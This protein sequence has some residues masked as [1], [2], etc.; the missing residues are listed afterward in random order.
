MKPEN[1]VDTSK[2]NN[3]LEASANI[4]NSYNLALPDNSKIA[5]IS[6]EIINSNYDNT[7]NLSKRSGNEELFLKENTMNLSKQSKDEEIFSLEQNLKEN[8]M[9]LSK[10]SGDKELYSGTLIKENTDIIKLETPISD[11]ELTN[12]ID[13]DVIIEPINIETIQ[14]IQTMAG[15]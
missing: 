6:S 10:R 1:T 7:M 8:T 14:D 4:N 9:N 15:Y 13:D 2:K 12:D 11:T 5:T 3:T